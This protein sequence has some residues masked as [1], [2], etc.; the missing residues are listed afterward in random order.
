MTLKTSKGRAGGDGGP[1][2]NVAHGEAIN[3]R[4]FTIHLPSAQGDFAAAFIAARYRLPLPVAGVI[5]T[6]AELGRRCG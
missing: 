6:L 2:G 1:L 4:V 3:D 5:A